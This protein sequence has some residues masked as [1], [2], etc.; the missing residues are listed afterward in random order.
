MHLGS[1]VFELN[2]SFSVVLIV[3]P[4]SPSCAQEVKHFMGE[5]SVIGCLLCWG[6]QAARQRKRDVAEAPSQT[7]GDSSMLGD[8]SMLGGTTDNSSMLL[9]DMLALDDDDTMVD[10]AL[11]LVGPGVPSGV[12]GRLDEPDVEEVDTSQ[13]L[14]GIHEAI[15]M[16]IDRCGMSAFTVS[17]LVAEGHGEVGKF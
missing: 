17:G 3:R 8:N 12:K 11:E 14:V 2:S 16:S 7:A 4:F 10:P 1:F 15:L 9:D 5:T 13:A 6:V